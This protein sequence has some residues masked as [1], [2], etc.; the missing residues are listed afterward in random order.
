MCFWS[1]STL[2][3]LHIAKSRE[4]T[5]KNPHSSSPCSL[6]ISTGSQLPP[7]TKDDW[8]LEQRPATRRTSRHAGRTSLFDSDRGTKGCFVFSSRRTPARAFTLLRQYLFPSCIPLCSIP[9][10]SQEVLAYP[11]SHQHF[12]TLFFAFP[13][14]QK[15]NVHCPHPHRIFPSTHLH[16]IHYPPS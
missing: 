6:S 14:V 5:T 13:T 12:S 9:S 1:E 2:C 16:F 11:S 10:I 7:L 8:E 4:T 3:L 15:Q